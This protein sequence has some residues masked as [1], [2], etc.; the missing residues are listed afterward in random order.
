[1]ASI[2]LAAA[3]SAI[4]GSIGGSII[5]VSAATIGGAVG[6]LA[7][8]T[9]DSWLVASMAPTQKIAGQRLDTLQI[10]ASTEGAVIPRVYGRMRVGGNI[11]WATDF[12]EETET[13]R[14]GGGGKGGGGGGGTELTE[15]FYFASLAVALCEGSEAN[16][17]GTDLSGGEIGG[18]G[19]PAGRGITGVGRIWADG[20]P[21]DLDGVTMRVHLGDEDQEPDPFIA[22]KMGAEN[23]P[24]YRGTAYVVFEDL[25][26]ARFGNRLPQL[27]FEVFRPILDGASAES[28]VR[29]VTLIPASGEF[30]YATEV[31]RR[32]IGET[33]SAENV[34]VEAH[35]ADIMVALDRLAA[36]APNVES[37]SLVVAWFG[38]D[39]RAGHCGIR[40]GVEV[41]AKS[42]TPEN[43]SVNGVGRGSA[44]LV[45]RDAQNRPAYGGTPSD[46]AVVQAI[47]ELKARGYRVTFYPFILMDVPADNDLPDPYSNNAAATGQPTYPWRGRIT[48][49]PAAGYAGSVDKS[50]AAGAQVAAFFGSAQPSDFDVDAERVAWDGDPDDWGLRRMILH[51]AHL[52]AAAGGVDTFLIGSELR[53]ITQARSSA[54]IYPAVAELIDLA[55]DVR[56][57]LGSGTDLSYAADWSEYFGHHAQ[58]GSGDVFFHLD[59]LWAD[60]EIDFVGIDNYMP[61]SDWRDGLEHLDAETA[62]AITDLDYLRG[63]IEGG[64]GFDW[65]Y[66]SAADREAQVRTP[67]TDGAAGKPWV[68]RTKDL[69][70]WWSNP[71]RNRPGGVESGSTTEWIPESKPIRFTEIG[72][73][74]VDRG[75]NQPNVFYDPKSAE[76]FRTSPAAGATRRSSAASSRRCSVTGPIRATTRVRASTSGG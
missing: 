20:K 7:G 4:G 68:F 17:S 62:D 53:E 27:S 14:H 55:A 16:P 67:I 5:G 76:S 9:I 35:S 22:A 50:G 63:N 73:P 32:E 70:S 12:R 23:T 6:S 61:L 58:D 65:H 34:N 31:V 28:L 66:A 18:G 13:T 46:S 64:E 47:R 56:S 21:M 41:S 25:P 24:A 57:I 2:I 30:A 42:T 52:C 3:G 11:I 72:C 8:A 43:W 75:P 59:P 45:S 26:L 38:D 60:D 49:S 44:H 19:G 48:C 36:C 1:M 29:A 40:P 33:T 74:A 54:A 15:Y 51:Y 10:T 37:V 69:R 71:H 39:L